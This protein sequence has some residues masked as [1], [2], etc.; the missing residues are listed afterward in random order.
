MKPLELDGVSTVSAMSLIE[1]TKVCCLKD[2]SISL[3]SYI[4]CFIRA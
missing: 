1:L 2:T 3:N 4:T